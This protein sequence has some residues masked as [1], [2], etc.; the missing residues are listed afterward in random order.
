MAGNKPTTST[1]CRVHVS[2]GFDANMLEIL[3]KHEYKMFL[4]TILLLMYENVSYQLYSL[5]HRM[6]RMTNCEG[7]V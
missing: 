4:P 2:H 7:A 1:N 6:I 3:Y 5:G